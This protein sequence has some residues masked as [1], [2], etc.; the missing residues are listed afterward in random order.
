ML[1]VYDVD[2]SRTASRDEAVAHLRTLCCIRLRA[3][4]RFGRFGFDSIGADL[5]GVLPSD[6]PIG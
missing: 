4:I 2:T 6:S 5:M 1:P 3:R